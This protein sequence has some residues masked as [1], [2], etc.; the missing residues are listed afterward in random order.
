VNSG[1]ANIDWVDIEKNGNFIPFRHKKLNTPTYFQ[2]AYNKNALFLRITCSE[3][4]IKEMEAIK[5]NRDGNLWEDNSLEFFLA[6]AK[7]EVLYFHFIIN[8]LGTIY[9]GRKIGEKYSSKWNCEKITKQIEINENN[10]IVS[11]LIPFKSLGVVTPIKGE[12]WKLNVCRSRKTRTASDLSSWSKAVRGFHNP[13][14]YGTLVFADYSHSLRNTLAIVEQKIL[15]SQKYL[16]KH[17]SHNSPS[18][19]KNL[20]KKFDLAEQRLKN[21]KLLLKS[22]K[23]ETQ[24]YVVSLDFLQSTPDLYEQ[25]VVDL[26]IEELL[27]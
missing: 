6:P 8:N 1:I 5:T 14:G 18:S 4:K 24:Q 25:M 13:E 27:K 9:D 16:R 26:K 23:I 20:R 11:L 17:W 19:E 10:W 22:D 2:L 12:I 15:K 21:V 7:G 3:N